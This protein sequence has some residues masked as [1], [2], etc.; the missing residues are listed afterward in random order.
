MDGADAGTGQHGNTCFNNHGHIDRNNIALLDALVFQDVRELTG[1]FVQFAVGHV[2][3]I[4]RVVALENN[5]RLVTALL[6]VT[7]QAVG[8]GV[9]LAVFKPFD[10]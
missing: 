1:F 4:S 5:G 7:V 8:G 2:A 10:G 6:Q 9:Q 3:G